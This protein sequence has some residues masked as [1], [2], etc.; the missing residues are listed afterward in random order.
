VIKFYAI[1]T[2][3]TEAILDCLKGIYTQRAF[4]SERQ[5]LLRPLEDAKI[6]H[7][8]V[9]DRLKIYVIKVGG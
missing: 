8:E 5:Q 1:G 2:S 9:A 7:P 6:E 4:V 3:E